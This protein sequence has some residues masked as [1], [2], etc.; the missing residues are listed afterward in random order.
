MK[1][2]GFYDRERDKRN[3]EHTWARAVFNNFHLRVH[4]FRQD[5]T[6]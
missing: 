3:K 6:L 4:Q 5:E 2:T 1:R